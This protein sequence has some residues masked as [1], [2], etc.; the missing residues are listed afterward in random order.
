MLVFM[1]AYRRRIEQYMAFKRDLSQYLEDQ[2][3]KQPE[4]QDLVRKMKSLLDGI[5]SQVKEDYPKIVEE[6]NA[7]YLATL[8]SD[9]EAARKKRAE[10][11]PRFT[12]AGGAQDAVLARCHQAAQLARRHAGLV[13]STDPASAQIA[14]EIRKQASAVLQNPMYHETK[15]RHR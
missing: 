10:L 1:K 14:V 12:A 13:L 11:H 3:N 8:G 4:R 5:P 15:D 6:L 7:Q 2:A 9:D